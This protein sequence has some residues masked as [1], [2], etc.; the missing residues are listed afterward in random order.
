MNN[1]ERT[2]AFLLK[3][4]DIETICATAPIGGKNLLEPLKSKADTH[5]LPFKILEDHKV[6]N[7]AEV[8]VNQGDLWCCIEG[9]PTFVYGGAMVEPRVKIRKDGTKDTNELFAKEIS[10]GTTIVL[11]PGDWLW[12]PAGEPHQHSCPDTARLIIIK[13]VAQ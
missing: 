12:I 10:G 8:H 13:I 4:E 2:S 7:E 6:V 11:K 9:N 1:K 3:K 5:G